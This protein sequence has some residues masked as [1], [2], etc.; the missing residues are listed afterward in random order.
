MPNGQKKSGA[1][2]H[3]FDILSPRE[4]HP[5]HRGKNVFLPRAELIGQKCGATGAG[6]QT[7]GAV[8]LPGVLSVF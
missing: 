4:S 1:P 5:F 3:R 2:L 8:L 7:K 6:E